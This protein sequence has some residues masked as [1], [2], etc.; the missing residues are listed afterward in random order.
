VQ[1]AKLITDVAVSGLVICRIVIS[2]SLVDEVFASPVSSW[3][4]K[5]GNTSSSSRLAV[6]TVQLHDRRGGVAD[7]KLS[8]S[9]KLIREDV[10]PVN[11]LFSLGLRIHSEALEDT[12][13]KDAGEL[14]LI[15]CRLTVQ[16]SSAN[17]VCER[18]YMDSP[19][20]RSMVVA[21]GGEKIAAIANI[22]D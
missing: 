9:L 13:A 21:I 4:K 1:L 12:V 11:G 10:D 17:D 14:L 6:G 5:R 2:G 22:E 8:N 18:M 3:A 7:E 16:V 20:G 19:N 15:R